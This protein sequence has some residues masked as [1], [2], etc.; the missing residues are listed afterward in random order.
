M[1]C[2]VCLVQ[3]TNK[4][5]RENKKKGKEKEAACPDYIQNYINKNLHVLLN[6]CLYLC[7]IMSSFFLA[8]MTLHTNCVFLVFLR[9]SL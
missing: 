1:T 4:K 9:V 3:S 7:K 6:L 5:K 2:I 8:P